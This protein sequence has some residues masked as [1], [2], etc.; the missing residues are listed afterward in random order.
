MATTN[1]FPGKYYP[2]DGGISPTLVFPGGTGHPDPA[3]HGDS[4][5][6]EFTSGTHNTGTI[7]TG[8]ATIRAAS[9][10]LA[11]ASPITLA[12]ARIIITYVYNHNETIWEV[13]SSH[14]YKTIASIYTDT[15]GQILATLPTLT[16]LQ[17]LFAAGDTFRFSVSAGV[18]TALVDIDN[19]VDVDFNISGFMVAGSNN[20]EV[21]IHAGLRVTGTGSLL[22]IDDVFPFQTSR[23]GTWEWTL[24]G[25]GFWFPKA[26]DTLSLVGAI[27]AFSTM[28]ATADEAVLIIDGS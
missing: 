6:L 17:L 21:E 8:A 18:I 13:L 16:T 4:I 9:S 26:G 11:A 28:G 19:G 1:L 7:D 10:G 12:T 23:T 24:Q 22:V 15:V 25:A 5:S 27:A 3:V 20:L 14:D 2:V